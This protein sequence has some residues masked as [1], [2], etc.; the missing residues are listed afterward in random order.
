MTLERVRSEPDGGSPKVASVALQP[1]IG[2]GLEAREAVEG[3]APDRELLAGADPA[4]GLPL[5]LGL[6]YT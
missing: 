1:G 2:P 5:L 4:F 3:S 6:V